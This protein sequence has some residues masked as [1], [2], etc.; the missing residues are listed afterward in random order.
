MGEVDAD[1]LFPSCPLPAGHLCA[2]GYVP[3]RQDQPWLWGHPRGPHDATT[4]FPPLA[5]TQGPTPTL[6][7]V[8]GNRSMVLWLSMIIPFTS[9]HCQTPGSFRISDSNPTPEV[10]HINWTLR[11]DQCPSVQGTQFLLTPAPVLLACAQLQEVPGGPLPGTPR[12]LQMR[13]ADL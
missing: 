7:R 13:S 1:L 8:W 6:L 10:E 5:P 3:Q 12:A 11:M 2:N 9:F 4:W